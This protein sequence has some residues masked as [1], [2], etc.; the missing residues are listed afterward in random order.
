MALVDH[1]E[2]EVVGKSPLEPGALL[3]VLDD[4]LLGVEAGKAL[5]GA[6]PTR[7]EPD[8]RV[9]LERR[10]VVAGGDHGVGDG[11]VVVDV[12]HLVHTGGGKEDDERHEL[13]RVA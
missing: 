7:A 10:D 3:E 2:V 6:S 1:D 12:L 13:G 5:H 4:V 8:G 11:H 9:A